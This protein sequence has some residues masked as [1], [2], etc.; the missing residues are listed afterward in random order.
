M[1]GEGEKWMPRLTSDSVLFW[2]QMYRRPFQLWDIK[3]KNWKP[4]VSS[5]P[6]CCGFCDAVARTCGA[7]GIMDGR[8]R[9]FRIRS[10]GRVA[11]RIGRGGDLVSSCCGMVAFIRLDVTQGLDRAPEF[12][13]L[14]IVRLLSKCQCV[15]LLPFCSYILSSLSTAHTSKV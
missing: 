11:R 4:A 6:Q 8:W 10:G 12:D 3:K 9:G 5:W 14:Y 1:I 7:Y 15:G 2:W 13:F